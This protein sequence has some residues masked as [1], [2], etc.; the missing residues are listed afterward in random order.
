MDSD[1][2]NAAWFRAA[3]FV[4]LADDIS[5]ARER[6]DLDMFRAGVR[7]RHDMLGDKLG[8]SPEASM[9]RV[10]AL[11]SLGALGHLSASLNTLANMIDPNAQ[12]RPQAQ[13]SET[14]GSVN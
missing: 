2:S 12:A 5:Y 10:H 6:L 11:A 9:V 7:D 8:D 1:S 13:D 14:E 4:A 3:S